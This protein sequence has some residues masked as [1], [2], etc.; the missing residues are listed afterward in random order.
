[1]MSLRL[2]MGEKHNQKE[3]NE[4]HTHAD[5]SQALAI[6]FSLFPGNLWKIHLPFL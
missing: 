4:Q 1:M 6:P 5:T 3:G 2:V